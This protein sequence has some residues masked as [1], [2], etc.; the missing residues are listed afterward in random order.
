MGYIKTFFKFIVR[1]ITAIVNDTLKGPDGKW[2][3]TS[4][5]MATA[6]W[7][8]LYVFIADFYLHGFNEFSFGIFASV[9]L[10]SKISDAISKKMTNKKAGE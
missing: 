1:V 8:S 3:R 4:L 7:A 2:S 9:A 6:W 10:G 5:T